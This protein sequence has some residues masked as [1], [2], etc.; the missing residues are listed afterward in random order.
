MSSYQPKRYL[1]TRYSLVDNSIIDEHLLIRRDAA[2]RRMATFIQQA[3]DEQGIGER[4]YAKRTVDT[5]VREFMGWQHDVEVLDQAVSVDTFWDQSQWKV[6][7]PGTQFR[8][9]YERMGA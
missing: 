8:R 1:V 9:R 2:I 4:P 7:K 5:A 3:C 6:R